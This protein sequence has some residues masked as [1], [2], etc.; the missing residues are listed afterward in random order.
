L[1]GGD[2]IEY[3]P[4]RIDYTRNV[5]DAQGSGPR[6]VR[7]EYEAREDTSGAYLHGVAFRTTV[8][9]KSILLDAPNPS[10]PELVWRYDLSYEQGTSS[11]RSRLT[12]AQRCGVKHDGARGG[13][14]DAKRFTWNQDP[15]GVTYA[16]EALWDP[17]LGE[18]ALV[19][20]FDGDGRAEVLSRDGS[21]VRFT[22]DPEQPLA[23]QCHPYGLV[24][25]T[26]LGDAKLADI[27]GDGRTRIL[28]GLG[29]IYAV[30]ELNYTASTAGGSG[31]IGC[32]FS[33]PTFLLGET[34]DVEKRWPIHVTDLDGDGLPDLIKGE[35]TDDPT[36]W[37]WHYRLNAPQLNPQIA[38]A[39]GASHSAPFHAQPA[40]AELSSLSFSTDVGTHRGVIFPGVKYDASTGAQL[41][42]FYGFGLAADGTPSATDTNALALNYFPDTNFAAFGDTNGDGVRNPVGY[43]DGKGTI[44]LESVCQYFDLY[45]LEMK[46]E[47]W[48][49][50]TADLDSDGQDELLLIHTAGNREVLLFRLNAQG[51]IDRSDAPFLA[52]TALGDFNGDGLLDVLVAD[53]DSPSATVYRQTGS[54]TVDRIVA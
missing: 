19:G 33:Y 26:G 50:E 25:G 36:S 48:H 14:L 5:E 47:E 24:P 7:F 34:N 28:A 4:S 10:T 21:S 18:P 2:F 31:S 43:L 15:P 51:G 3:Y 8:R 32:E 52:P 20:D 39:F 37:D 22:V 54:G 1:K 16:K 12:Q 38:W 23:E 42:N 53:D 17:S 11:G 45:K 44:C 27:R 35:S 13:C 6:S 41:P 29:P 49:V 9:L 46:P 30:L 40:R